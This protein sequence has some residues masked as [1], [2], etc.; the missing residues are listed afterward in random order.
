MSWLAAGTAL[1]RGT[2][3]VRTSVWA[4]ALGLYTVGSAFTIAN[5]VPTI[6]FTL[7]AGGAI[8]A[9]FVPQLVRAM[10]RGEAEG[11]AY[12]DRLLTVVI[13]VLGPLTAGAVLAAPVLAGLYAGQGWTQTE[14]HLAAAFTAWCLPQVFFYGVF[15]V[16]SQVLQARGRPGPMTWAPVANNMIA[17]AVGVAFLVYG[18]VETGP[19]PEAA[20]SVSPAEIALLGGGASLG[21][22][23]QALILV[24]ALRTVGYRFRPRFDLRGA[25][26][27]RS[28]RLA[29]WTLVFVAANQVAYS[30]TVVVANTAGKAAAGT[31]QWAAGLPSYTNA[32]MIMLVPHAVVAVSLA[33]ARIRSMSQ[34]SVHG[35]PAEVGAAVGRSLQDAGRVLVPV[36]AVTAAVGPSMTRLLFPGNPEPDTLYMGLVL[37]CFAPSIVVYSAQY[38]VVRGMY[39]LEDTR[40]PALVQI[41]VTGLQILLAVVVAGVLPPEWVV[42]GLAASFALAYS[43]GLALSLTLLRRSAGEPGLRELGLSYG[44]QLLAAVPAAGAATIICRLVIDQWGSGL[45]SS[46]VGLLSGSIVFCAGY[47]ALLQIFED[48][49]P[50]D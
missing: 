29:V 17:I 1:S 11:A 3:F 48:E 35:Q 33:N 18:S 41:L 34:A 44:R 42:A 45:I 24:P 39:A 7:V 26:L 4:A 37:A 43:A 9:V 15:G 8:S 49:T 20:D 30:V 16:L 46:A 13:V 23:V 50:V 10:D 21:V 47:K 27:G 38:L 31:S 36:A 6:L 12:A 32:Y 40:R 2:G 5:T 19:Q 22:V 14:L 28:A 25:G